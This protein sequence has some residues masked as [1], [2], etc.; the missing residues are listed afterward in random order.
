MKYALLAAV[1]LAAAGCAQSHA[2]QSANFSGIVG[3]RNVDTDGD[4][5]M[6]GVSIR[7]RGRAGGNV[8]MNGATIDVVATVGGD[9]RADGASV[10][11]D[12][13][14][15][16]SSR[17]NAGSAD[18]DG[19]FEGAVTVM[20]GSAGLAGRYASPVMVRA[21]SIEFSGEA[22]EPVRFMGADQR[23]GGL[24]GRLRRGSRV[25]IAGALAA[26]G[27]I[28]A[29]QV[30]FDRGASIGAPVYVRA[31]TLHALPDTIDPS[32]VIHEA[33]ENGSCN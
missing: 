26:G 7:L 30:R 5:S 25:K 19:E 13:A 10:K 3:S 2:Q 12:S 28:C 32:R 16:G 18:L 8:E 22:L 6:N 23:Q 33:R 20:A 15:T 31:D 21:R 1:L 17:I 9:L 14:V 11:I 4:V 24:W 27:E 29:R